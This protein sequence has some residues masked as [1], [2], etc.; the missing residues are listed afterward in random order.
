[1]VDIWRSCSRKYQRDACIIYLANLKCVWRVRRWRVQL[2]S[3]HTAPPV[4]YQHLQTN[5]PL[6]VTTFQ[7][8]SAAAAAS[9]SIVLLLPR[10][11]PRCLSVAGWCRWCAV[12]A[13]WWWPSS[14]CTAGCRCCCWWAAVVAVCIT[15]H[16]IVTKMLHIHKSPLSPSLTEDTRG[17]NNSS[18]VCLSR[19]RDLTSLAWPLIQENH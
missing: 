14:C 4:T 16:G 18:R 19:E 11:A 5:E 9:I 15:H 13:L 10:V 1:M 7:T 12:S 8:I 3:P 2:C 17:E 6:V